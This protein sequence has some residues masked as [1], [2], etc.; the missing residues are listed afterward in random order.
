MAGQEL[1]A[2]RRWY[3]RNREKLR[4][5]HRA[6]YHANKERIKKQM[7]G[8]RHE[9][10]TVRKIADCLGIT[11]AEVRKILGLPPRRRYT[12]YGTKKPYS[13]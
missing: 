6:Y 8:R 11:R 1:D 7:A 5:R 9:T 10:R 3:L 2:F 13:G 12:Q 4:I